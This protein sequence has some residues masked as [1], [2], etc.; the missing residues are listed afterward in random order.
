[1]HF[2][3]P[4]SWSNIH[5]SSCITKHLANHRTLWQR[6]TTYS[7][8]IVLPAQRVTGHGLT[9]CVAVHCTQKCKTSNLLCQN[10]GQPVSVSLYLESLVQQHYC[11]LQGS[12]A[13]SAPKISGSTAGWDDFFL[14]DLLEPLLLAGVTPDIMLYILHKQHLLASQHG[15][16]PSLKEIDVTRVTMTASCVPRSGTMSPAPQ[17]CAGIHLHTTTVPTDGWVNVDTS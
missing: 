16:Q 11:D 4:K 9:C 1:M 13:V 3:V 7:A 5:K 6:P 8:I 12:F 2:D 10:A 17:A 15:M 14:L